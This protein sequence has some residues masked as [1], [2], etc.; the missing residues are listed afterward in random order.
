MTR[1]CGKFIVI[2]MKSTPERRPHAFLHPSRGLYKVV[3]L[4]GGL[5]HRLIARRR[6]HRSEETEKVISR[7]D[8][9][10]GIGNLRLQTVIESTHWGTVAQSQ[11]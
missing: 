2:L 11:I 1:L 7:S 10:N 6:I 9:R 4:S 8:N 5:T 3:G